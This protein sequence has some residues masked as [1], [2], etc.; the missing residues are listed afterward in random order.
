[1]TFPLVSTI[2]AAVQATQDLYDG[3]VA[4]DPAAVVNTLVNLP[5][6]NLVDGFLNGSGTI[7]GFINAPPGLLTPYDPNFG[8]W[9]AD[10]SPA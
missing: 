4:G 5:P 2:N 3:V 9:P 8:S 6:A 1:M 10:R 7:L